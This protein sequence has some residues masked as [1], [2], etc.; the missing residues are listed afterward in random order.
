[1]TPDKIGPDDE[2]QD[3][4]EVGESDRTSVPSPAVVHHQ[5]PGLILILMS[6]S[7]LTANKEA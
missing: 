7:N 4:S 1:M 6:H 3:I 2:T 5:S